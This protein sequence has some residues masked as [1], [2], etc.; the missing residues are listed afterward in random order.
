MGVTAGTPFWDPLSGP[1]MAESRGASST[2]EPISMKQRRIE[3]TYS[4]SSEVFWNRIFLDDEYKRKMFIEEL[5]FQS[6]RVLSSETRGTEVHRTIEAVPPLGDLPAPL[7]KLLANGAGYEEKGVADLKGH[8][9]RLQ[10]TPRS[11]ASKL[12]IEGELS[13]T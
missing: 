13:T 12:T 6:W 5:N 11:L 1:N 10:V 7:K 4:C 2:K 9:Y 8:R 3:H